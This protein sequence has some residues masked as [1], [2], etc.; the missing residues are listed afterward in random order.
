MMIIMVMSMI[1]MISRKKEKDKLKCENVM[2]LE[3]PKEHT[4]RYQPLRRL[5]Y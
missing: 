1:I 3:D 5:E 2:Y 4:C